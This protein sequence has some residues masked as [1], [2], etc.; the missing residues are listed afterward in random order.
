MA[1]NFFTDRYY[2]AYRA[3]QGLPAGALCK[4]CD[5]RLLFWYDVVAD[6]AL[7]T[8]ADREV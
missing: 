8:A 7:V 2:F 1:G 3:Q 6:N 5:S 4:R